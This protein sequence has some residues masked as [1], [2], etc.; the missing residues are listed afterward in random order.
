VYFFPAGGTKYKIEIG[1]EDLLIS[2]EIEPLNGY[3]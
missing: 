2:D 3:S 1:V